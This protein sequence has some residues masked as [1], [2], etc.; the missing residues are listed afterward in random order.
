MRSKRIALTTVAV[1]T[2]LLHGGAQSA[3]LTGL[4]SLGDL[5]VTWQGAAFQNHIL[6]GGPGAH[7]V[8]NAG[9]FNGDGIDDLV[10]GAP[11][12]EPD[13]KVRAGE[14]FLIYGKTGVNAP[15]GL[16]DITQIGTTVDGVVFRGDPFRIQAG[17]S[18]SSAGDFNNDGVDDLLIGA[19]EEYIPEGLQPNGFKVYVVY[20]QSGANAL[21]GV[22]ELADQGVA[23]Q[24]VVFRGDR[25]LDIRD[26]GRAVASAG[27][28]NGDGVDDILI[29][30][31]FAELSEGHRDGL[32]SLIYGQS[33]AAELSGVLEVAQVG[34]TVAGANFWGK[35]NNS[36][37]GWSV[38]GAGDINGDGLNDLLIGAHETNNHKGE[39][40]LIHG[41][42]GAQTLSGVHFVEE[43]ETGAIE[44]VTFIG[45][46]ANNLGYSLCRTGDVN[47]D[48]IDDILIGAKGEDGFGFRIVPGS[49]Y[50]VYGQTGAAALAG[51]IQASEIG[52]TVAGAQF[53]SLDI[54]DR[55][56][57]AVS[58]GDLNHDGLNDL[59]IQD[60]SVDQ[61]G[62]INIG[63]CYVV[64]GKTGVDTL[65]GV[66]SLGD[67]GTTIDG[68]VF[69]GVDEYDSG[70]GVE[71]GGDFNGDGVDDLL[72]ANAGAAPF[73]MTHKVYL[74]YGQAAAGIVA[75]PQPMQAHQ[76]EGGQFAPAAMHPSLTNPTVA[77]KAHFGDATNADLLF[78]IVA[79][80]DS[81]YFYNDAHGQ[82]FTFTPGTFERTSGSGNLADLWTDGVPRVPDFLLGWDP[83]GDDND[84]VWAILGSDYCVFDPSTLQ[85]AAPQPLAD[86]GAAGLAF[87][88]VTKYDDGDGYEVLVAC[89]GEQMFVYNPVRF[90][91]G[92]TLNTDALTTDASAFSTDFAV[93]ADANLD[94]TDELYLVDQATDTVWKW[95]R[96]TEKLEQIG[97]GFDTL[98]PGGTDPLDPN[99]GDF[100]LCFKETNGTTPPA[101]L[102]I[103]HP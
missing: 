90:P 15:A 91:A 103:R 53:H 83:D 7:P 8:A 66:M 18:V 3:Q 33:G 88:T 6:F 81:Y 11:R 38:S 4:L 14:V 35:S 51:T 58:S 97:P 43:V 61:A 89:S 93:C 72:I 1:L 78:A 36:H 32:V 65:S 98:W 75:L 27:D 85:F 64:Y 13:G 84:E 70:N 69:V 63:K 94:G 9:D 41:Q 30:S 16:Y 96:V 48:G 102:A 87:D 34:A 57:R 77:A 26:T 95:N 86:L 19:P 24:G 45:D 17:F 25:S 92:T 42:A 21:S 47:G 55:A 23:W 22:V 79:A 2:I 74:I 71:A 56:G 82:A 44:G 100:L 68:V 50:L 37:T 39:V 99:R 40:Y 28:I 62:I 10:I 101:L 54:W 49:A 46:R 59:V 76:L 29:S 5:G 73:T 20:G 12:N 60:P 31:P 52:S 67:V 80:D